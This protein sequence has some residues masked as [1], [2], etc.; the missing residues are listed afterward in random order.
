MTANILSTN[1]HNYM[2]VQ[3]DI[4]HAIRGEKD[5]LVRELAKELQQ[6]AQALTEYEREYAE[7][8]LGL[9][10]RV[11]VQLLKK[12][13]KE[14]SKLD[15]KYKAVQKELSRK[16]ATWSDVSAVSKEFRAYPTDTTT[17]CSLRAAMRGRL[18]RK[19]STLEEQRELVE[20]IISHY[21][22]VKEE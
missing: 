12:H 19:T 2:R 10:S 21:N 11:S 4:K 18:H 3:H 8:A 7:W 6:P 5:D 13:I 14:L 17:L 15:R 20:G 1:F 16:K 9:Y 22:K